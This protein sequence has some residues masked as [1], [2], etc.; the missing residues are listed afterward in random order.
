MTA[1]KSGSSTGREKIMRITAC[2][3]CGHLCSETTD[4]PCSGCV[5]NHP[6]PPPVT[7][8]QFTWWIEKQ[9]EQLGV[10]VT[11]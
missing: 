9:L 2:E 1:R 8:G 5:D 11:S 7:Y 4:P 6:R 10:K 3:S